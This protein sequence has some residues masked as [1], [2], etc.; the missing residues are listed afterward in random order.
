MSVMSVPTAPRDTHPNTFV[1]VLLGELYC[2]LMPHSEVC[3]H[4]QVAGKFMY[5][6]LLGPRSVQL[7]EPFGP[8][9][10]LRVFSA[11]ILPG[12]AGL[13]TDNK[14]L[15]FYGE[16]SGLL[17][18]SPAWAVQPINKRIVYSVAELADL[19]DGNT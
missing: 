10:D 15:Y 19:Y 7:Y 4:M 1:R 3:M 9:Q 8:N 18:E 14:G 11:P 16:S 17:A 2:A 5:F 12:E 6:R 13:Y